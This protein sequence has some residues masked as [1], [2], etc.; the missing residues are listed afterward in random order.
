MRKGIFITG[1][2]T[3]V[4]KTWVGS[5]LA[6]AI[7]H[8]NLPLCVRKPIESGCTISSDVLIPA[9]AS[10][11]WQAV[12]QSEPLTDICPYRFQP[13]ISPALAASQ[14]HIRIQLPEL[15]QACK[16][17]QDN[18]LLVE[19]AGGFYS[20]LYAG[21]LNKDLAQALQLPLLLV[22]ADKLG[23]I[24]H[25]LLSL[26]AIHDAGLHCPL[27]ILNNKHNNGSN[28][29]ELSNLCDVPIIQSGHPGWINSSLNIILQQT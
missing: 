15:L 7:Y 17:P 10:L 27:V 16:A 3:D 21:G 4:G 8:K 12:Q 13:A 22:V 26:K 5:Q 6:A 2:D 28:F 11:Y 25:T 29:T 23:C 20:P 19:G 1:T 24:N 9:D 14:Q 18:F